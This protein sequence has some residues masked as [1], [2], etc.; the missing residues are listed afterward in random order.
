MNGGVFSTGPWR[1]WLAAGLL[2]WAAPGRADDF[3]F[4]TNTDNTITLTDY[5]G[6]GGDVVVP[7]HVNGLPVVEIGRHAFLG[8]TALSSIDLPDTLLRI[9]SGAFTAC[10]NLSGIFIPA[11]VNTIEEGAFSWCSRMT[12]IDVD[13]NNANF[14]SRNG[15]L[16]NKDYSVMIRCPGGMPGNY[17]VPDGVVELAPAAFSGC[18]EMSGV[19]IPDGVL[20]IGESAFYGCAGLTNVLLPP[21][22]TNVADRAFG[23]CLNLASISV[24]A[25]NPAY[26]TVDGALLVKGG[27]EY[28]QC[29]GGRTGTYAI[30]ASATNIHSG[31]FSGCEG[32]TNIW[33]PQGVI[34]IRL[35]PF[36]WCSNLAAFEV[37]PLNPAFVSMDGVLYSKDLQVL[38]RYPPGKPGPCVLLD[39][40]ANIADYAFSC[41]VGLSQVAFG[42]AVTN[43]GA[44]V[45]QSCANMTAVIFGSGVAYIHPNAFRTCFNIRELYFAG[46]APNLESLIFIGSPTIYHLP[47]AT[48]WNALPW[49][50]FFRARLTLWVPRISDEGLGMQSD[51]FGFQMDWAA[52]HAVVVEACTNLA[53]PV[54]WPLATNE[55]ADGTGI[56][57]DKEESN[58]IGRFYRVVPAPQ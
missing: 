16:F 13:P 46:N 45:F 9:A 6:T 54:W 25:N 35:D 43:I 26:E 12:A 31:A 11:A 17:A 1:G 44:D 51:R 21:S 7:S 34:A 19:E 56:F 38:V 2:L 23:G 55:M 37:D 14:E 30:P 33:F 20:R 10:A 15:V 57:E 36:D 32:L 48:G 24:D 27:G 53:A 41:C 58:P 52:G 47:D 5:K 4:V 22:V 49:Y 29:P 39:S 42:N 28:V 40:A 3:T 8:C 50:L 18:R